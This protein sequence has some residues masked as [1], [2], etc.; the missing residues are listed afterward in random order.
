MLE[1]FQTDQRFDLFLGEIIAKDFIFFAIVKIDILF[2]R[3]LLVSFH[4]ALHLLNL[5]GFVLTADLVTLLRLH[6]PLYSQI[7]QSQAVL[8]KDVL[9]WK[10][11]DWPRKVRPKSLIGFDFGMECSIEL[12]RG[13]LVS[14]NASVVVHSL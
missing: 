6:M 9:N 11:V 12:R 1:H 2:G 7:G 13:P 14:Q 5:R 3:V 10:T 8:R 4:L